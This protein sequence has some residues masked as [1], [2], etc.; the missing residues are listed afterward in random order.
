[1]RENNDWLCTESLSIVTNSI[2]TK[3]AEIFWNE[4]KSYRG[5]KIANNI[6]YRYYLMSE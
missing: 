4:I 2:N 6:A 5:Y 3:F 1:M